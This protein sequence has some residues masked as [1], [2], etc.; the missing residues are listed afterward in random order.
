MQKCVEQFPIVANKIIVSDWELNKWKDSV[1]FKSEQRH[2][3][4]IKN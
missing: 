1:R 4:G 2:D 3:F